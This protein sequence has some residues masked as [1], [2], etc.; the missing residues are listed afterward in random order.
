MSTPSSG[1]EQF[2]ARARRQPV[3]HIDGCAILDVIAIR[4]RVLE[5]AGPARELTLLLCAK[6]RS[7][8]RQL[9]LYAHVEAAILA[10]LRRDDQSEEV[11]SQS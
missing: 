8:A 5:A 3:G 6:S 4:D 7:A 2:V 11:S 10:Q 9:S 1:F